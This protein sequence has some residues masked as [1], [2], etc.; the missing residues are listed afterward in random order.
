MTTAAR[1]DQ[2]YA[3]SI[4]DRWQ[5]S[6]ASTIFTGAASGFSP[7]LERARARLIAAII[8]LAREPIGWSDRDTPVPIDGLTVETATQFL[9]HLPDDR[10]LPV[11]VP[12]GDGGLALLWEDQPQKALLTIDHAML[13]LVRDPGKPTSQHFSPVRFDGETIP[14]W[15]I[16]A[17]PSRRA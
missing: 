2:S 4:W 14:K 7:E 10:A 8:S 11:V 17:L 12:D 13:L 3:S 9:G 1:N 15:L 6:S 16:A 5:R